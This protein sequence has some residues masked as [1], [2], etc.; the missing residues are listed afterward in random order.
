M[1]LVFI[2]Y[3]G[4]K[5]C[6]H[7]LHVIAGSPLSQVHQ[8]LKEIENVC[9]CEGESSFALLYTSASE[10]NLYDPQSH[11]LIAFNG[12]ICIIYLH[13]Y[14]YMHVHMYTCIYKYMYSVYTCVHV[15]LIH[16]HVRINSMYMYGILNNIYMYTCTSS[17]K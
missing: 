3:H 10:N 5:Q 4:N 1:P 16:I 17:L 12:Y 13:V 9:K 6:R 8:I 2:G 11:P 14:I 7:I 15:C